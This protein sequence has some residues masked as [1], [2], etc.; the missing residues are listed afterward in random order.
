MIDG[1]YSD[2]STLDGNTTM[3]ADP[4]SYFLRSAQLTD[5]EAINSIIERA[6]SPYIERI[7]RKPGPMLEDYSKVIREHQVTVAEINGTIAGVLVLSA[8]N[9]GL[10]L[11][12]IAVYPAHLGI[13]R[14]LLQYAES[15]G[16]RQGFASI[17]LYTHQQM[18]ENQALY[19]KIGYVEYDRRTE[20]GFPR[21]Y[22]KKSLQ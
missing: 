8:T 12:N 14:V 22:M 16:R 10:L 17:Y 3:A 13:G 7:G 5:V 21:I 9:E 20:N 15:E 11:E 6:Y 19:S 4:A 18:T 2:D 1:T